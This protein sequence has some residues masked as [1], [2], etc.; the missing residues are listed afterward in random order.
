MTIHLCHQ[1]RQ[2]GDFSKDQVEAMLKAGVI[3]EDTMAWTSGLR[4]WKKLREILLPALPPPVPPPPPHSPTIKPPETV[5]IPPIIVSPPIVENSGFPEAVAG[6][7]QKLLSEARLGF[8]FI[9]AWIGAILF[10]ATL[11]SVSSSLSKNGSLGRDA[12]PLVKDGIQLDPEAVAGVAFLITG[13][14]GVLLLIAALRGVARKATATVLAKRKWVFHSFAREV[15]LPAIWG[16]FWRSALPVLSSAGFFAIVFDDPVFKVQSFVTMIGLW[17][18]VFPFMLDIPLRYRSRVWR[19][20]AILR[21]APLSAQ[22]QARA[23]QRHPLALG[24]D[25]S[26]RRMVLSTKWVVG[27]SLVLV[28]FSIITVVTLL[29]QP[30]HARNSDPT[31][32][33]AQCDLGI[34]SYKKADYVSALKWLRKSAEQGNAKAQYNLAAMMMHGVGVPKDEAEA[35]KLIWESARQGYA[36]AQAVLGKAYLDGK[37][38]LLKDQAEAVKWLKSASQNGCAGAQLQLARCYRDG[39][40]VPQNNIKAYAWFSIVLENGDKS[41]DDTNRARFFRD[42]TK[43]LMSPAEIDEANSYIASMQR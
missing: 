43:L 31:D 3:V 23:V 34:E 40:G 20:T 21:A 12:R 6:E 42:A 15:Y 10:I 16:T 36:N 27:L 39:I 37:L 29:R 1:G 28:A 14:P 13:G 41:E 25:L 7:Q 5:G 33:I 2:L 11:V 8:W 38:G 22:T 4:E 9:L 24:S 30:P 35:S 26:R 19:L 18:L 17:I 32:P